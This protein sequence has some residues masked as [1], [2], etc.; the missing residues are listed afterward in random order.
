M[1]LSSTLGAASWTLGI[2]ELVAPDA[3]TA[4]AGVRPTRRT[5]RIVRALGLRECGHGAAVLLVSRR[6]VWTRVV[7]DVLDVAV[8][9]KG[10]AAPSANR[11]RGAAALAFLAVVGAADVYAA[12]AP[13]QR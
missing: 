7:G 12:V 6:L 1:N 9:G 3:V 13:N 8:L 5:R 10:L 4:L 11:R 2:S